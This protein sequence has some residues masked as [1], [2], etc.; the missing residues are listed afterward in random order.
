MPAGQRSDE[1]GS[2]KPGS[3]IFDVFFVLFVT[4]LYAIPRSSIASPWHLPEAT[5]HDDL[6]TKA[7]F[8]LRYDRKGTHPCGLSVLVD[9][10]T[11]CKGSSASATEIMSSGILKST[12]E[13]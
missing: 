2:R 4:G 12:L 9:S 8:G 3:L 7:L 5:K 10:G 11:V 13:F 6:E 1:A